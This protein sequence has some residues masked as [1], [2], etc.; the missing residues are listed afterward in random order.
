MV[1][2]VIKPDSIYYG[3]QGSARIDTTIKVQLT[4][5]Y[6]IGSNTKA[7]TSF[8]AFQAIEAKKI[9]LET[10]FIDLYPEFTEIRGEYKDITLADLLSH[11]ARLRQCRGGKEW[12]SF[13]KFKGTPLEKRYSF[14]E[15]ILKQKPI[16]KGN[17]SNAGYLLA[18]S[19]LEKVYG[20]PFESLLENSMD[21][22]GIATYFG[23]P[24]EENNNAINNICR[25]NLFTK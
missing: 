3:I 6:H 11:N 18:A 9:S 17:Y 20:L 15:Y 10:K 14:A 13:Y 22:L 5:K 8:L 19:M 7:F 12:K 23:F 21:S 25:K 1:V 24:N 16:E 2:A 4:D